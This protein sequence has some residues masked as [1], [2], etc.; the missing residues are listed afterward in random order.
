MSDSP[1]APVDP[2]TPAVRA[3]DEP[4]TSA[5]LRAA[6]PIVRAE[7]PAGG[8]VW[9]IT[10][11]ALAR[12]ALSDE[13]LVKDPAWAPL[14]WDRWSAGLEPTAAEQPSLTTLDGP[15]HTMLRRAHTPLLTARRVQGYADRIATLARELL[16]A[17]APGPV[18]LMVEFTTRFPLA[19]ICEVLGV[20]GE[21]LDQAVAAC[22][23]LNGT[24]PAAFAAAMAAFSELAAAAL[25]SGGGTAVELRERTPEE[26]DDRQLHYLLFGLIFASQ[27]TTDAALGFLLAR[28]LGDRPAG[29]DKID[30]IVRDG[31]RRHP[32]APFTLWRF[33]RT[34]V[35]L[36]G[37]ALP[38]RAPVLVDIAGINTAPGAAGGPDLT[39]G[40]G[41]HFCVG[42]QLAQLEL[43]AVAEVLAADFPDARLA[44]PY[45]DLRRTD[46]G[47]QGSRLITLPVLLRG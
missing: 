2:F 36:G 10:E 11:D 8:P 32:P 31:L 26:I 35:E 5:A 1:L 21:R 42:A 27:I 12:R 25:A 29:P 37:V 4:G 13:R 22:R 16:T 17:E 14:S 19:V 33:T 40:A 24:D 6:G 47:M 15:A 45:A 46:R 20:P 41:A 18:D 28:V 9:I 43:R 23:R 38:E 7:A 39:F 34:S 44:V 30:D 3:L